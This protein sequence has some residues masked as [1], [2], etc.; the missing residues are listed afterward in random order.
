MSDTKTEIVVYRGP[1]RAGLT[2]RGEPVTASNAPAIVKAAGRSAEFAWEEFVQAEIANAHTCKNYLHAV[3]EV[4]RLGRGVRPQAAADH[5][6][7]RRRTS[8]ASTR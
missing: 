8:R 3:P 7:R 2:A 4:P 6:R 5:P 1:D